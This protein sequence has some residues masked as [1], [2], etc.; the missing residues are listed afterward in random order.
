MND[1]NGKLLIGDWVYVDSSDDRSGAK[2]TQLHSVLVTYR[3]RN[4]RCCDL[5]IGGLPPEQS[6]A[7][8]QYE[9]FSNSPGS[10]PGIFLPRPQ[11]PGLT[12]TI[13]LNLGCVVP[14]PTLPPQLVR[15]VTVT[16][17]LVTR[18]IVL[19]I[20]AAAVPG[21]AAEMVKIN[22]FSAVLLLTPCNDCIIYKYI[23]TKRRARCLRQ[24]KKQKESK[25]T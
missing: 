15:P 21:L 17:R 24:Q 6:Q 16:Q 14:I 25:E 19:V 4:V 8:I 20:S 5:R 18:T 22:F 23:D 9:Q 2:P 13:V 10:Q 3:A 12:R 7:L 11:R 1:E